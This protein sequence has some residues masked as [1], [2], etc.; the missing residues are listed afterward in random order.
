VLLSGGKDKG[1]SL[2]EL[3]P[4]IR[5][6]VRLMVVFG[7]A[8][9]RMEAELGEATHIIRTAELGDAVAVAVEHALPKDVVLLSPACSSFDAY[10]SFEE[11]GEHFRE[12]IE[13][14]PAFE[15]LRRTA[16]TPS[17]KEHRS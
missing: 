10:G 5:Q 12:L 7:E 11:R 13:R 17:G 8:A 1:L 4:L 3:E 15:P 6:K 14:L 16:A 9:P 2:S